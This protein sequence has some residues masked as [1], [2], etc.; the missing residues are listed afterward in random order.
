MNRA[1]CVVALDRLAKLPVQQLH[2]LRFQLMSDAIGGADEINKRI[3]I[4]LRSVS[5]HASQPTQLAT[6]PVSLLQQVVELLVASG[7]RRRIAADLREDR[8]SCVLEM[9]LDL[10]PGQVGR[11]AEHCWRPDRLV[12]PSILRPNGSRMK[13]VAAIARS[14][15]RCAGLPRATQ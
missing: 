3:D 11:T 9:I 15:G 13:R 7:D 10:G 12:S 4:G 8:L 6:E 5:T 2:E 1:T 14:S